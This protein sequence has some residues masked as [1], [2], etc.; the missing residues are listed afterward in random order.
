MKELKYGTSGPDVELLQLAMQRSGYYDDAVDGV[1][2]P[3]TLNALRRFQASFGLASDG[4]VGKNTWKQLRPFLVGYFTTKIR[5]GDTYYRLA[6]RYD[7]TV[8][9]IQTANPRYNSENLEIGATL[10]VPYG[11]DLVPTNVHYTSELMELLIEGLYVRYPFIQEG[12]IGKSVMGKPIYS[13]II[14]NGEKQAFF[15]ASHHANEWITTPLV[16]KFMESYLNAYMN[17]STIL[18]R[19][20][21]MLY[22]NTKLFAVPMVNPD[23]V[24]LVNG[25]IDKSNQYYKEA[26]AISAEYSFIRFPDG[27]KANITGTDLNLNYPAGWEQAKQ[28]KYAKGY[29]SPAPRDFVGT[30]PLSAPESRA[31]YEFTLANNFKLIFAYHTQ[32]QVIYWKF[33][34]IEPPHGYEIGQALAQVSG[35]LLDTV[36]DESSN[37][38]YKDW[39]ILEYNRPGYTV[40]AGLGMNPLPL[41]QFGTMYRDNAGLMVTALE[42]TAKLD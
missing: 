15:N 31:V 22:E 2:G 36:P 28:I 20:A 41:A 27:W 21:E 42:E 24:D 4:I 40:E 23:G 11:F 12:S 32:G 26:T 8:A 14:G 3:R 37:A 5:P 7:T 13:I 35:Y 18:G 9:A 10:I 25:A 6:K 19:K 1:F 39:F 17:K 33:H 38:G 29:V 30:E 34:E 16:M